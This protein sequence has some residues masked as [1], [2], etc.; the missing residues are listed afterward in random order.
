[1]RN[2]PYLKY[3]G[4]EDK[5]HRAVLEYVTLQYPEAII[6][7]PANEG[8]RGKFEQFK[9][10]YL[11]VKRGVPDILIFTPSKQYN[12]LAIE[13]KVNYNKPTAHQ[14]QWIDDLNNCKWY[15]TW[16]NTFDS[17]KDIIDNYFTNN[18]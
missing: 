18:L 2:N 9:L 4:P 5:L 15:A 11:G 14:V 12:G 8:K 3:L 16:T 10:K 13:L 6:T 7:H 17:T 1:M